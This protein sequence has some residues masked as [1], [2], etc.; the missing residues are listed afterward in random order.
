MSE[1]VKTGVLDD[2]I[3]ISSNLVGFSESENIEDF[4]SQG[5][6]KTHSL[7]KVFEGFLRENVEDFKPERVIFFD[8]VM[9]LD[10]VLLTRN[11]VIGFFTFALGHVESEYLKPIDLNKDV[12]FKIVRKLMVS[13]SDIKNSTYK[14]LKLSD[15]YDLS[16]EIEVVNDEY[17]RIGDL[18][19]NYVLR[20]LLPK[21]ERDYVSKNIL[22]NLRDRDILI[23]DGLI[24]GLG[25]NINVFGHVKTFDVGPE[26]L[27]DSDIQTFHVSS[28]YRNGD[29]FSCYLDLSKGRNRLRSGAFSYSRLDMKYEKLNDE[30]IG[31]FKFVSEYLCRLTS[32]FSNS[33]RF[34][35]N[36][37]I[38]E[39]LER[40]LR[41]KCGDR[42]IVILSIRKHLI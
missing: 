34:P 16:Y 20:D 1:V 23:K 8:S 9:R 22:N 3:D 10:F 26:V 11:S 30:V 18:W 7:E 29:Y 37:P 40:F 4:P 25:D 42:N 24:E 36:L 41:S 32:I 13:K 35:Q 33:S 14:I 31:R 28:L 17:Q 5:V 12:K 19:N 2:I 15:S 38:I 21:L 27:N 6:S 39:G